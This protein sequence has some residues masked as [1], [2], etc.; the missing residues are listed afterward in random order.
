VI[1]DSIT[2]GIQG[3]TVTKGVKKSAFTTYSTKVEDPIMIRT[4]SINGEQYVEFDVSLA[5]AL[6]CGDGIQVVLAPDGMSVSLQMGGCSSFFMNRRFWKDQGTK[7]SKDSSS[8]TAHCKVCDEFKKKES[9]QDGIVYGEYQFVQLPCECTGLVEETFT[10]R[11][12]TPIT[13]PFTVTT[14]EN[15]MDVA[16]VQDHI[17]FMVNKTFR[18]KTVAQVQREKKKVVEVTHSGRD[19]YADYDSKGTL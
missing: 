14:N 15:G 13:I 12:Q 3:V 19:I 2:S 11:V 6:M 18:M 8:V 10:G 5:A 16:E 9:A 4:V 1:V 17:Q 7:Y